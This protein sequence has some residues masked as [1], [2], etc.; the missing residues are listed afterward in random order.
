MKKSEISKIGL[1]LLIALAFIIPTGAMA[2]GPEKE[3]GVILNNAE[4]NSGGLSNV[5]A[6][7]NDGYFPVEIIDCDFEDIIKEGEYDINITISR[8]YFDIGTY[9]NICGPT[10]DIANYTFIVTDDVVEVGNGVEVDIYMAANCDEIYIAFVSHQRNIG[11]FQLDFGGFLVLPGMFIDCG[12]GTQ[13]VEIMIPRAALPPGT[14]GDCGELG[15]TFDYILES[16]RGGDINEGCCWDVENVGTVAIDCECVLLKA[17]VDIYKMD[18]LPCEIIYETDFEDQADIYNNWESYEGDTLDGS[19]PG[20]AIDTWRWNDF[21]SHSP[22]H[23]MHNSFIEDSYLGNQRDDI[24]MTC[25]DNEDEDGETYESIEVSFWYWIEGQE[26]DE[27][28][29][30]YDPYKPLDYGEFQY[31]L[32]GIGGPWYDVPIWVVDDWCDPEEYGHYQ[33]QVFVFSEDEDPSSPTYGDLIWMEAKG[34]IDGLTSSDT[35]ICFQWVWNS[36]VCVELGGWYIDDVSICGIN[37][38][39][40]LD[41]EAQMYSVNAFEMCDGEMK[42]TFPEKY[43]FSKGEYRLKYWLLVEDDCHFAVN[44]QENRFVQ[45]FEVDDYCELSVTNDIIGGPVFD[46]GDDLQVVSTVTNDGTI[47]CYDIPLTFTIKELFVSKLYE[48]FVEGFYYPTDFSPYLFVNPDADGEEINAVNFDSNLQDPEAPQSGFWHITDEDFKSPEHSWWCADTDGYYPAGLADSIGFMF[49]SNMGLDVESFED[50]LGWDIELDVNWRIHDDD[51]IKI[52]II[53]GTWLTFSGSRHITRD[54]YAPLGDTGGWIH[55]SMDEVCAAVDD[56]YGNPYDPEKKGDSIRALIE[57]G[58]DFLGVGWEDFEGIFFQVANDNFYAE[59]VGLDTGPWS[60]M[61][62][63]NIV[64]WQK[65]EGATVT[66]EI[67]I[68]PELCPGESET[69]DWTDGLMWED[70]P[71]GLYLECKSV[72]LD[73][74]NPCKYINDDNEA[75]NEFKVITDVTCADETNIEHYDMTEGDADDDWHICSSGYNNY[76]VANNPTTGVYGHD[77]TMNTAV[78]LKSD[79]NSEHPESEASMDMSAYDTIYFEHDTYLDFEGYSWDYGLI[80]LCPD[81]SEPGL[82]WYSWIPFPDHYAAMWWWYPAE[83]EWLLDRVYTLTTDMFEHLPSGTWL[84]TTIGTSFTDDMGVRI[85]FICDSSFSATGW[86]LDNIL[87]HGGDPDDPIWEEDPCD[88]MDRFI[89][90]PMDSGDWWYE[91]GPDCWRCQDPLTLTIP[92]D[93]ECALVWEVDIDSAYYAEL[94]F[95]IDYDLEIAEDFCFLEFSNDGGSNWVSPIAFNGVGSETV[96]FDMTTFIGQTVLIRWRVKTN[97]I[98]PSSHVE[99]C[100]MC[101]AG[102]I[103]TVPPVTIGTISGTMI[104]GWYSSPVTFTATAT[105]DISGVF[106]TYYKIDGG[107]TLTY[108]APITISVNGVHQ[109]EYWSVDNVGNEEDHKFTCTFAIDTGSAP[110]VSLTAPTPGLY[111]F[112]NQILSMSQVFIIGGFTA[113]ATASDADSGVYKVEFQLDG[114]TFGEATSAPYSA[115]CGL[116]NTGDATLTAIA[117]DFTGQTAQDSMTIKYFKFL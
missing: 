55:W 51:D 26:D 20:G 93:V 83:T 4:Y 111:L 23:S 19:S 76:L 99:V 2:E 89:Y 90:D 47:C 40:P 82:G 110:S 33:S 39:D 64:L 116:K 84:D 94:T 14:F 60:G 107:S 114:T 35:E 61:K 30:W 63:D 67:I 98:N 108:T 69:L 44:D 45:D 11:M 10:F 52:G 34:R 112:G 21:K 49:G 70:M 74:P 41:F 87:I 91:S 25:I 3:A 54:D 101:I 117:E 42:Y 38:P 86:H 62:I 7:F 80:E 32:N 59:T 43:Y 57:D 50:L 9:P 15:V 71:T 113:E 100:N 106:A 73:D 79:D 109:I 8:P 65:E 68:I 28:L 22:G 75:C 12:L 96:T 48:D 13:I 18:P 53:A 115:Y 92:N 103:D 1:S 29:D 31:S 81:V 66:E 24:L 78:I 46:M 58:L 88:T 85:R 102:Y 104:H 105:D 77:G 5:G 95:D 56:L 17:F 97:T 6:L 37:V 27:Y 16:A 72:P 36:D